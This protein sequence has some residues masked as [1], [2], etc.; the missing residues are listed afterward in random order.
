MAHEKS[1]SVSRLKATHF[2][3]LS[4]RKV[5]ADEKMILGNCG[6]QTDCVFRQ[7]TRMMNGARTLLSGSSSSL[8]PT[9]MGKLRTSPEP[10]STVKRS[11]M[12]PLAIPS[13]ESSADIWSHRG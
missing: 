1:D 12:V 13:T 7:L 3:F 11:R 10:S 8:F 6:S 4:C 9:V 5:L 2:A